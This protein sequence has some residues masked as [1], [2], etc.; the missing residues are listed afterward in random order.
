MGLV[1]GITKFIQGVRQFL[2][3][4]AVSVQSNWTLVC[5]EWNLNKSKNHDNRYANYLDLTSFLTN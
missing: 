5:I 2:V 4:I 1:F 3:H